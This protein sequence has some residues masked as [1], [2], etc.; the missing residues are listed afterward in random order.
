MRIT[1]RLF[2][3][4]PRY[5]PG[6]NYADGI[7]VEVQEGTTYQRLSALLRLPEC[8]VGFFSVG[9]IIKKADDV[10]SGGEEVSIFMHLGGG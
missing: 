6:Y 2:G 10:V 5:V 4:L 7:A 9:G 1:V 8:E 3:V